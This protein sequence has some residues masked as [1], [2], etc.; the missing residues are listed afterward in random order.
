MVGSPAARV[1]ARFGSPGASSAGGLPVARSLTV[2]AGLGIADKLADDLALLKNAVG[3]PRTNADMEK[4]EKNDNQLE[5]E[6]DKL[7]A[8]LIE[9]FKIFG[10]EDGDLASLVQAE[11][12][13]CSDVDKLTS[14]IL[15]D[16]N[17]TEADVVGQG[18]KLIKTARDTWNTASGGG[19]KFATDIAKV[20]GDTVAARKMSEIKGEHQPIA[21]Q[22]S[23]GFFQGTA[24]QYVTGT[25]KGSDALYNSM[26]AAVDSDAKKY[27]GRGEKVL[28]SESAMHRCE[29]AE[30]LYKYNYGEAEKKKDADKLGLAPE[31][32]QPRDTTNTATGR[33]LFAHWLDR[34][35]AGGNSV[36]KSLVPGELRDNV[37]WTPDMSA[38]ASSLSSKGPNE[39]FFELC[40][41][42]ALAPEWYPAGFVNF[43][44]PT[45][46]T[47]F[48]RP[49][50][51]DGMMSP[52]WVQQSPDEMAATGGGAFEVINKSKVATSSASSI[53]SHVVTQDLQ[54]ALREAGEENDT[55]EWTENPDKNVEAGAT[56]ADKAVQDSQK[57]VGDMTN[58]D[59]SKAQGET[60]AHTA[61]NPATESQKMDVTKHEPEKPPERTAAE[62][63]AMLGKESWE[64]ETGASHTLA[65]SQTGA[66]EDGHVIKEGAAI[67]TAN[68]IGQAT[69]L[70]LST[71]KES[72]RAQMKKAI[73]D[74]LK[75]L[76]KEM[77]DARG[78][79]GDAQKYKEKLEVVLANKAAN[80]AKPAVQKMCDQALSIMAAK[81]EP[82]AN[83]AQKIQDV[84]DNV[85]AE[86]EL[87]DILANSLGA[88][89]SGGFAGAVGKNYQRVLSVMKSGNLREQ[90]THLTNFGSWFSGEI[91]KQLETGTLEP[92]LAQVE[93]D[94]GTMKGLVAQAKATKNNKNIGKGSPH[95]AMFSDSSETTT[96]PGYAAAKASEMDMKSPEV[97]LALLSEAELGV[98]ARAMGISWNKAT[99]TKER[100]I[101]LISKAQD[102][103]KAKKPWDKT[104]TGSTGV[105]ESSPTSRSDR[106]RDSGEVM[107]LSYTEDKAQGL[108]PEL[109]PFLEGWKANIVDAENYWIKEAREELEMPIKAGIS[110]TTHRFMHQAT[111]MGHNAVDARLACFGHLMQMNA[112]SYH[113]I[114]SAAQGY[115]SYTPGSYIPLAPYPNST[116]RQ[117]ARDAKTPENLL[118]RVVNKGNS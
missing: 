84:I 83:T 27:K 104:T 109:L 58:A 92:L 94:A 4:Y 29:S 21:T 2:A 96:T 38:A 12:A 47:E 23:P 13:S 95:K 93:M 62:L 97:P 112:H 52:L 63:L 10:V 30:S 77:K 55:N 8:S 114:A 54:K 103:E 15:E 74:G 66:T 75:K 33:A 49:T 76:A 45:G 99:Q 71:D 26:K 53:A 34:V 64:D 40:K 73:N 91:Y 78:D 98:K 85:A 101:E 3:R 51:F 68:A 79:D 88:E 43:S 80:D 89:L 100:I 59:R 36:D 70:Y 1:A 69:K 18:T 117:M 110:G 11:L 90:M 16:G 17:L 35:N 9:V 7:K 107:D 24:D 72:E 105:G 65:A 14:L 115:V 67:T 113:E 6:E 81:V 20:I 111:L 82:S 41:I 22:L 37:W 57:Q 46:T 32:V 61:A 25:Y 108:A 50:V 106:T 31:A 60:Q 48:M 86:P 5:S 102:A 116:V 44:I 19:E 118:E 42:Y 56:G 87:R 28:F 39:A